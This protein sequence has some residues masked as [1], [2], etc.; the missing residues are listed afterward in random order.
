MNAFLRA[1]ILGVAFTV[2]GCADSVATE[3]DDDGLFHW[4]ISTTVDIDAPPDRVWDVL[5]NLPAYHEWN[6]FIVDARGEVAAGNALEL[7]MVLPGRDPMTIEPQ[8]LVV[9]AG[10]ELRW[11]GRLFMPGLF[12]GEHVFE[13]ARI[14]DARTRVHHWERFGGILLPILR[15]LIYDD[16]VAAFG[17]MNAALARRASE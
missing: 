4:K 17:A 15:G 5:V 9:D 16:T 8:L 10:R 12:D 11:K 7:R 13:L 14:D 2:A 1:S 3:A 6:P